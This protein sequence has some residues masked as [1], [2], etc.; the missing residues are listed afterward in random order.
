MI[1]LSIS[2][3]LSLIKM[4]QI[5]F[6]RMEPFSNSIS[7]NSPRLW[8]RKEKH[9]LEPNK[10][11]MISALW[12]VKLNKIILSFSTFIKEPHF[13]LFHCHAFEI[14]FKSGHCPGWYIRFE[15]IYYSEAT[16]QKEELKQ[17]YKLGHRTVKQQF[18]SVKAK[19]KQEDVFQF[20]FNVA[21]CQ[22]IGQHFS[23]NAENLEESFIMD[24][25]ALERSRDE[26]EE[27]SKRFEEE[28]GKKRDDEGRKEEQ[29]G[30]LGSGI[31]LYK[32]IRN[33]LIEQ[34]KFAEELGLEEEEDGLDG[35]KKQ[36]ESLDDD[37]D[38]FDDQV[39]SSIKS[40]KQLNSELNKKSDTIA[41]RLLKRLS[42]S[43][44]VIIMLLS[45]LS[46]SF[47]MS[48]TENLKSC[49]KL[50]D[51]NSR[52][53]AEIQKISLFVRNLLFLSKKWEGGDLDR[54]RQGIAQSLMVFDNINE[55]IQFSANYQSSD[56]N[57][58]PIFFKENGGYS[59]FELNQASEQIVTKAYVI[60]SLDE[61]EVEYERSEIYFL[62]YNTMNDYFMVSIDI[63]KDL[64][65]EYGNIN[66]EI[67]LIGIIF[68]L[69][70]III[71][72]TLSILNTFFF[73]K[74]YRIKEQILSVFLDIPQ[75]TAK[76]LYS[77]Y[78]N[79]LINISAGDGDDFNDFDAEDIKNGNQE[80]NLEKTKE[81]SNEMDDGGVSFGR[82]KKKRFKNHEK[83]YIGF[84]MRLLM[85]V[86]TI[87]GYYLLDYFVGRIYTKKVEGLRNE[88]NVSFL[89]ESYYNFILNAQRV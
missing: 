86:I 21:K 83:K 78:E 39:D 41:T 73:Q 45:I 34:E 37:I 59:F 4:N 55:E 38:D 1:F 52:K 57:A 31:K 77:K 19:K 67:D 5:Y 25:S 49:F 65:T 72:C 42:F 81:N 14:S 12:K 7:R 61:K 82:K 88:M 11:K 15:P 13:S 58:V 54:A 16:T 40:Q 27:K 20:K 50:I 3:S 53:M 46:Y 68:L 22:Y 74:A 26:D 18:L 66:F 47:K 62:I 69:I 2:S 43:M 80:L 35:D 17:S 70:S 84:F 56:R 87:M 76:T 71:I 60:D 64:V 36:D 6:Q 32:L 30:G 23:K 24:L 9:L 75:K 89:A 63:Y 33:R 79:F 28:G 51:L 44:M 8:L 85:V 10:L 48:K 29:G